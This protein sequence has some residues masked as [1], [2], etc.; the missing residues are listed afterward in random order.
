MD[1]S[2]AWFQEEQDGPAKRIWL[3]IWETVSDMDHNNQ[4]AVNNNNSSNN[5]NSNAGMVEQH[6]NQNTN[7]NSVNAKKDV[8]IIDVNNATNANDKN[9]Y[10]PTKRKGS[11]IDNKASTYNMNKY[12]QRLVGKYSGCPWRVP[13][14]RY[15]R[16]VI[17][18]HEEIDH[19]YE[20]MVPT[21]IEHEIRK[22]VVSRIESVVLSLWPSACVEVFGSFRTGLYLPTSD[23]DL[24]VIGR[25]EKL[26]LRTL[27]TELTARGIAEPISIRVL[28]KASVPIIKLTD[29]ESQVK[30]DISFNM[31]S[32]VQ[33]AEFIKD[34]KRK[35]PVLA[36]L[37]LVLKQ[38]LLQRD[39]NEVFTGGISSYSLILMCIS[40]LQLHPR[41]NVYENANL[42]VLLLEFLELYGRKFNYMKTGISV[43]NN[44][45]YIP[46]EELQKEMVDGHRPSLL[47][48]EDPLTPGND[49]GRSSYGAL[50]VKQAFEYAYI[51]LAQAVS[52]LNTGLNDCSRHS[53]LGRIIRVTDEVIE[54][55]K[56]VRETFD[57]I[58]PLSA[59]VYNQ[60]MQAVKIF[61]SN[62]R[63]GSISSLDTSEESMDSDADSNSASRDI[64]P[65]NMQRPHNNFHQFHHQNTVPNQMTQSANIIILDDGPEFLQQ[66][67]QRRA[68]SEGGVVN[69][70]SIAATNQFHPSNTNGIIVE[71]QPQQQQRQGSPKSNHQQQFYNNNSN[72]NNNNNNNNNISNDIIM[73][74]QNSNNNLI[75]SSNNKTNRRSSGLITYSSLQSSKDDSSSS[76]HYEKSSNKDS[77]NKVYSKKSTKRKK[78]I[79]Q[80][81]KKI[82]NNSSNPGSNGSSASSNNN[83]K[84]G[85]SSR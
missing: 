37:V 57:V 26:P 25:W 28:D 34:T 16:G 58:K 77:N 79:S 46:K 72:R 8:F 65:T 35:F 63:R 31:Q 10:N 85:S 84:D 9:Y 48:I 81:D 41:Q 62:R 68:G 55:R 45:R 17:G 53:I 64:S 54:Y 3:A 32:G 23:I 12:E 24:V 74:R 40:F 1:P 61:N 70:A 29:R 75:S 42:G 69:G 67:N 76:G 43:K 30:V 59:V 50:Q 44:G 78:T 36:K 19:F 83:Q 5:I 38:F 49:I 18:L 4:M 66:Q 82:L 22:H 51:V 52:P 7:N 71:H 15:G 33:S 73:Q 39:L 60:Q 47:C 6:Q 13:N 11:T 80:A 20:H 14:F 56:W 2:V 21:R 27:E